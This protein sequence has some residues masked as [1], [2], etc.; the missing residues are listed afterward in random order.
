M[1]RCTWSSIH[2]IASK[3]SSFYTDDPAEVRVETIADLIGDH[4]LSNRFVENTMCSRI[5]VYV[6]G[7]R[8]SVPP[9]RAE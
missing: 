7:M 5:W 9:G 1:S 3:R 6:P 8:S 2:S 4:R